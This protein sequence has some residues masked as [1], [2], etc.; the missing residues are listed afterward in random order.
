MRAARR[1]AGRGRLGLGNM[2]EA[3]ARQLL[4]NAIESD[5]DLNTLGKEWPK[6]EYVSWNAGSDY[7]NLDG[8]FTIEELEAIVW[9][10][11]NK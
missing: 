9:W 2:D 7:A 11:K 8:D 10:M 4:G 1:S 3:R 6:P 5:N